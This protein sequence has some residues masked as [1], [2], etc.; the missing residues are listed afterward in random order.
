MPVKIDENALA[1]SWCEFLTP[2]SRWAGVVQTFPS[3]IRTSKTDVALVS[4]RLKAAAQH[5]KEHYDE[6]S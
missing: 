4:Q 1:I 3:G 5:Y 2:N 6:E